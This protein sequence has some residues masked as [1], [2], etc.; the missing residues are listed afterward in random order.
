M[1]EIYADFNDFSAEGT[2]PL[3]CRG[4]IESIANL[5][6]SLQNGEKVWL[7]D[8]ELRVEARVYRCHDDSW[9]ARSDWKF[10]D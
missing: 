4:S 1:K 3:T 6:E 7:T 2:L 5:E 8:G 9:E 10:V